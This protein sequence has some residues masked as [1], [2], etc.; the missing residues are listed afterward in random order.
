MGRVPLLDLHK[1]LGASVGEFAGIL[2]AVSF[3]GVVEEHMAVRKSVG[4]F[5]V[6]HMALI[7]LE[8][9][10][11]TEALER[12]VPR[13]VSTAPRGVMLGPTAFLNERGGIK[14]DIMIYPLRS[15]GYVIVG[16]AVN[17]GKDARWLEEHAP[18]SG[19]V[20]ILNGEY[21]LLAVQGPRS[22][23]VLKE[24]YEPVEGLRR[25]EFVEDVETGVGRVKVISRSG[26]T[27]EDGF[28]VLAETEAASKLFEYLVK[29]G[30][31]P[32][33]LAARDSLRLEMG[34]VLY[35]Q[36][37]DEETTPVEARYW[38]VFERGKKGCVGC[39]AIAAQLRQGVTRVRV[40]LRTKKGE[41][42]IPRSGARI[43]VEGVEVGRVT[44]G[45]Y[46]PVLE[47]AIAMGYVRSSH[48]LI[49]MTVEVEV[50]GG[51]M[52]E[53]RLVDFPFIE[54]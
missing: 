53:A 12:L 39:D 51:R 17:L 36:D 25:L 3:G 45:G 47:R 19:E 35:G 49:G 42:V 21:C 23:E 14:D 43:T 1:R 37:I 6:S 38:H 11:W 54:G 46:S 44:S 33:G 26:W 31:R 32:C 10:G 27:G 16:N 20:K 13:G 5:D 9:R 18:G 24:V 2:T 15:G 52:V 4:V 48:A 34:Y 29:R 8:G 28:E 40:G 22:A 7:L 41:R 50:R 30:V